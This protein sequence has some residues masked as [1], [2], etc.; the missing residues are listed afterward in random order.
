MA[1]RLLDDPRPWNINRS[2]LTAG[3]RASTGDLRLVI[4]DLKEYKI[5]QRRPSLG[6]IRGLKV[7]CRG[8]KGRLVYDL[9]LKKPQASTRAG[10]A[11][12]G[13]REIFLYRTLAD[14]LP[15]RIPRLMAAN[16]EG[17]WL[18]LSLLTGGKQAE[19]W[20]VDEYR[21]AIDRL[22][23]LHDRFWEL[24][25]DLRIFTWLVRP[26][27][28][29]LNIN[30]NLAAISVR[31]L[32]ETPGKDSII[33]GANLIPALQKLT[34]NTR[35]VS[36]VLQDFPFTLIHG[37]YWPGNLYI[38]QDSHLVA[39]DWQQTGIGPGI[40]D[41]AHF[42]QMSRWWFES[43][44]VSPSEMIGRYREGL[45]SLTGRQWSQGEWQRLWDC[46][47]LWNFLTHWLEP[48]ANA[49]LSLWRVRYRP[50]ESV[51]LIPVQ[52]AIRRQFQ[53]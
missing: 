8:Q 27:D 17:E 43:L 45:V 14:Q 16:P 30:A 41:L 49:P 13:L 23:D 34:S 28:I 5:P 9:V 20:G 52:E 35:E 19:A 37:D 11:G 1:S 29:D 21:M 4:L 47:L 26:L 46:A 18:A 36:E 6:R 33:N 38:D 15:L 53:S 40:L 3:L 10:T 25:D 39:L 32:L 44:P 2:E 24:G 22:V 42:I 48:L 31:R 7:I 12:A 50:L 51:W